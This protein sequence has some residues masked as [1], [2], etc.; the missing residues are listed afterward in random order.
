MIY[1]EI[2]VFQIRKK[3]I[4]KKYCHQEVT[5]EDNEFQKMVDP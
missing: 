2:L 1:F 4:I 3:D 5:Q